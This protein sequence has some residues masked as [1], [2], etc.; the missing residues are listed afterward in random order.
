MAHC[1]GMNMNER[2][3]DLHEKKK[4]KIEIR[5]K[6]DVKT[7]EDLSLMYTPGVGE[8]SR[9]ISENIENVWKYTS[10]GNWVAVVSDGSAVLGLGD[11][12]PE[13]ALPV[14]EGKVILFKQFGNVDAFPLCIHAESVEE[15]VTFVKQ[16]APT[17]GGINLE[18]IAAPKCFEIEERLRRE[19][20]IPVFHDDQHGTAIVV[21]AALI[22]ALQVVKK[23]LKDV[24]IIVSGGGAAGI[25]ITKLL[26]SAG[27]QHMIL[28]DSKGLI[29]HD[30][31]NLN[32]VKQAMLELTN[33]NNVS[34]ALTDGMKG[35]DVFIG[36][37][38]PGIVSEEMV[39]S[40]NNDAIVFAMANPVPEIM[41]DLAKKA[42]ARIVATGRSDFPNQV[43]NA[44]VF[45]GFFRGIFDVG[46]KEITEEMKLAAAH[47]LASCVT[48]PTEDM[49]IPSIY[50]TCA[51]ESV[52]ASI[53]DMF[54]K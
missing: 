15:I 19:L 41:P 51:A 45:P 22:N 2:A 4:G 26:L 49:V 14:M 20:D 12:G 31:D 40:M 46:A 7:S 34:G 32:E 36:V 16:V 48:N 3:L 1:F 10:R 21:M 9:K 54:N 30:R 8:V 52:A 47:G 28:A 38:A 53:R 42:G 5:S 37:S 25:A 17:F 23:E 27:A 35:A 24:K 13:A 18:D 6:V 39:A 29:S 33:L 50:D 11:I 43:N 44:L